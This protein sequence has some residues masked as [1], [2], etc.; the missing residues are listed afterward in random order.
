MPPTGLVRPFGLVAKIVGSLVSEKAKFGSQ[1]DVFLSSIQAVSKQ[2]RATMILKQ[3][4]HSLAMLQLSSAIDCLRFLPAPQVPVV[5]AKVDNRVRRARE[6]GDICQLQ[7][8]F[9]RKGS[10]I[11]LNL[12][13]VTS[14]VN[15]HVM[16]TVS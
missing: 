14:H 1:T 3:C 7:R 13:L 16:F 8:V 15:S 4:G 11:V 12:V 10:N 9:K 2:Q 5:R 6:A